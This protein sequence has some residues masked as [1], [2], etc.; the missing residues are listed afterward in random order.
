MDQKT[1]SVLVDGLSQH[2]GIITPDRRAFTKTLLG[3]GVP[4]SKRFYEDLPEREQVIQE[5]SRYHRLSL[6]RILRN[7]NARD[8]RLNP[9]T[10]AWEAVLSFVGAYSSDS[11]T[12][13]IRADPELVEMMARSPHPLSL[14]GNLRTYDYD[15]PD[16]HLF[17]ISRPVLVIPG[18]TDTAHIL[19]WENVNTI[20]EEEVGIGPLKHTRRIRPD[21][22]FNY[23]T[24]TR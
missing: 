2:S 17:V 23:A 22:Y 7:E 15:N 10:Q 12:R 20:F 11:L 14:L 16:E 6:R 5:D 13:S 9:L 1:V 21:K 4:N 19:S 8:Y 24:E 18:A 3:V